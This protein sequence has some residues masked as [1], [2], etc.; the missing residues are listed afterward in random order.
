M[1]G[2]A[3]ILDAIG[4]TPLVEFRHIVPKGSAR[5]IAKLESANPT[6]SMKDRLA[7]TI[8][9]RAAAK[10]LLPPGGTVVEYTAGTTGISLA[11]VASALGYRTHFVFS[12]AFSAEKRWTMR[13]YGAELTDIT[14]DNGKITKELI[15]AMI[16]RAG[17]IAEQPDHWWAD[18]LRNEDGADGYLGLGE[19]I[20]SQAD[21]QVDAFVH[22][23]STAHS[24]HGASRALRRHRPDLSVFGI[25][26]AESAVLSGGP[27]GSH[28]IEG[29][30]LGFIPPLWHRDEVTEVMTVSTD[31]AKAMARRL[32]REEA[33]FAGTS[34][35]ANMVAALRVADR[36]G[37][38]RTVATII[39]DSGLRYVSTDVFRQS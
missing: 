24:I 10:G 32:A 14:S 2:S 35:G 6:G 37:P 19:E 17:E 7:R 30:G 39:V 12:D 13:A 5:V 23:V 27:P 3:H 8:I 38:G 4:N 34:T 29:I 21:G 25:E 18:Q 15:E 16:A 26:P 31:E 9:E 33:I 28:K 20:W 36:L 22:T 11:F 1:S